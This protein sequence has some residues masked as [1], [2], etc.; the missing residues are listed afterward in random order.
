[1][2]E[3]EEETDVDPEATDEQKSR[4]LTSHDMPRRDVIEFRYNTEYDR[5]ECALADG[6]E[7]FIS[8][9]TLKEMIEKIPVLKEEQ[10]IQDLI[11]EIHKLR[12]KRVLTIE[13]IDKQIEVLGKKQV[14]A[15][16][17]LKNS[18]TKLDMMIHA[19]IVKSI[20][21]EKQL[22]NERRHLVR[23]LHIEE[24]DLRSKLAKILSGRE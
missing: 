15:Q 6:S 1:M 17:N 4:G 5:L 7:L 12:V 24:G 9:K 22:L 11:D 23:L 21:A 3:K 19:N 20:S 13:G 18:S 2:L 8:I 16:T 14:D 10:R